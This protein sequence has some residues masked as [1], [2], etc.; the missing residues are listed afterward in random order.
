MSYMVTS[1]TWLHELHGYMV[2]SSMF[3]EYSFGRLSNICSKT[4]WTAAT[5]LLCDIQ[6]GPAGRF[7]HKYMGHDYCVIYS[8]VLQA[9]WPPHNGYYTF[10]TYSYFRT[11]LVIMFSDVGTV[12]LFVS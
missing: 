2:D 6:F 3:A 9:G 11:Y 1:V 4:T 5:T 8:S 12:V 10:I 7:G